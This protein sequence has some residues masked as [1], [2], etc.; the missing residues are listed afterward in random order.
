M[1]TTAISSIGTTINAERSTSAG[2]SAATTVIDIRVGIDTTPS[3]KRQAGSRKAVTMDIDQAAIRSR[4]PET[5][6]SRPA[7]VPA[8][9]TVVVSMTADTGTAAFHQS[10]TTRYQ[11]RG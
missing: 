10:C 6:F 1:R 9:S 7:G 5:L 3:T 2:M 8:G 4:C 11:W